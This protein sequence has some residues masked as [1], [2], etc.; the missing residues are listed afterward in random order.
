MILFHMENILH[1]SITQN[2]ILHD[3]IT[4]V[5]YFTQFYFLWKIFYMILSDGRVAE[6]RA[7]AT[8]EAVEAVPPPF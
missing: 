2:M 1:D 8:Y 6:Y 5:K 3:S 4:C 7:V